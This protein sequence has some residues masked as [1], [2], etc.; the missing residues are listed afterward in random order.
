MKR[1][2]DHARRSEYS[3]DNDGI[4]CRHRAHQMDLLQ[5]STVVSLRQFELFQGVRR[6]PDD[7]SWPRTPFWRIR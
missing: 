3:T 7:P 4:L 5:R 1:M 2:I 6:L